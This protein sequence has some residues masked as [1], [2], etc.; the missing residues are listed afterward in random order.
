MGK[1]GEAARP[2]V[3]ISVR[4]CALEDPLHLLHSQN[5][6][7]LH[8]AKGKQIVFEL[9]VTDFFDKRSDQS[10]SNPVCRVQFRC[11]ILKIDNIE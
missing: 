2:Q 6:F 1:L 3:E 11:F 5:Y 8:L 7:S 10:K 4:W 9:N